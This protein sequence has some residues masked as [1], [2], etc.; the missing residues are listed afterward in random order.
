VEVVACEGMTEEQAPLMST[1][2]YE[3]PQRGK[4]APLTLYWYDGNCKD[5]GGKEVPNRPR[6]PEGV[7][8]EEPL[9]DRNSSNGSLFIGDKGIATAETYGGNPRLLPASRMADYKM[10]DETIP[11]IP[12][13][14]HYGDWIQA[15]KGGKPACSNFDYAGPFSEVVLLGN[16]A[17]RSGK[18]LL[19]DG[20]NMKVTNVPEA[21]QYVTTKYRKGWEL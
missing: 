7:P 17:L 4:M 18:K 9:G 10:P 5:S 8:A 11:R 14:N 12:Q 2:K 16:L 3:F 13:T 1:L 21:N 15:C 20:P 6:R 19:W